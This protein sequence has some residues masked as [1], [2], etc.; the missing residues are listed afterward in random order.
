MIEPAHRQERMAEEKATYRVTSRCFDCVW[1]S[2]AAREWEDR[3][4]RREE[5]SRLRRGV[6]VVAI[7]RPEVGIFVPRNLTCI[8]L[9]SDVNMSNCQEPRRL[10]IEFRCKSDGST[11]VSLGQV[12][13]C[14][15]KSIKVPTSVAIT[16]LLLLGSKILKTLLLI[17]MRL[18]RLGY[19]SV[20]VVYKLKAQV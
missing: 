18:Y 3:E 4:D 6:R 7:V 10:E 1:R 14:Q 8:K 13:G 2:N 20:V 11:P 15:G 5:V 12:R 16:T 19:H 9:A 17:V